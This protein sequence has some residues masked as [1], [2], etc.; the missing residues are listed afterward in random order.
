MTKALPA[1]MRH[2]I[3]DE[4]WKKIETHLPGRPDDWSR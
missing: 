1:F 2:D 4:L 3:S